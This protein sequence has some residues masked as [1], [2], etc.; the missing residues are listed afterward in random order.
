MKSN[1]NV[2]LLVLAMAGIASATGIASAADTT[3]AQ[4]AAPATTATTPAAGHERHRHHGGMLVGMT[5]HAAK[6]LNLTAE[7]QA[8]IK[9]IM[10]NAHAQ[11]KAARASGRAPLDITVLGNPGDPNYAT[12]LQGAK[13]LAAT[14]IQT[15]SELQGQIYNVLTAQQKAQL[16]T[17]LAAMKAKAAERRAAWQQ[18]HAGATGAG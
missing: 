4:T 15:E 3:N 5:L 14:R 6:Q 12:A 13:T 1:R 8:T 2:G 17:V 10:S 11:A 16:P 9:T 18:E 7:Q